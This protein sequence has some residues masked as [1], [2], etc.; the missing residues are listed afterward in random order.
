MI[1]DVIVHKAWMHVVVLDFAVVV[2]IQFAAPKCA[3]L[4]STQFVAMA[5]SVAIKEDHIS[6]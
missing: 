2:N 5:I 4:P 6:D 1:L 3:V